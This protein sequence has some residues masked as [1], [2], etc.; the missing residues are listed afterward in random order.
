MQ[1]SDSLSGYV[2][3]NGKKG[4]DLLSTETQQLP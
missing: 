4:Q 2:D 1:V 3:D